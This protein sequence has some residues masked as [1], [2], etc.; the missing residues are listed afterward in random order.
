MRLLNECSNPVL[1]RELVCA[2]TGLWINGDR[3]AAARNVDTYGV[4]PHGVRSLQAEPVQRQSKESPQ[5]IVHFSGTSLSRKYGL[6]A[7]TY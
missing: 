5:P 3:R 2:G 1:T 4:F 7:E 6:E